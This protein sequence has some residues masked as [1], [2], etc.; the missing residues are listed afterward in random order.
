MRI[1]NKYTGYLFLLDGQNRVRWRGS[2]Q[3]EEKDLESLFR[4]IDDLLLETNGPKPLS[5]VGRKGFKERTQKGQRG[6]KA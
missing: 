4:G 6:V 5:G 2:G 1:P 3:A